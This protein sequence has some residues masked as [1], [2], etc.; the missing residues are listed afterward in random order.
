MSAFTVATDA[1]R[2]ALGTGTP[3][4]HVRFVKAPPVTGPA[5]AAGRARTRVPTVTRAAPRVTHVR[6]MRTGSLLERGDRFKAKL[7]PDVA[8]SQGNFAERVLLVTGCRRRPAGA[9]RRWWPG[10]PGAGR[11]TRPPC[12]GSGPGRG[13]GGSRRRPTTP[14]R[15]GRSPASGGS[16][17]T[18]WSIRA[19]RRGGTR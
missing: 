5:A 13:R 12:P 6:R 4:D 7:E 8:R 19:G 2:W 9:P 16:R 3:W 11:P 17:P 15:N 10:Q 18:R 14:G 1:S